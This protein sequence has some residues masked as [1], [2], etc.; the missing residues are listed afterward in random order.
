[1]TDFA[2]M[3]RALQRLKAA[4]EPELPEGFMDGVWMRASELEQVSATRTRLA[5]YL[6]MAFIGLGAGFGTTQSTARAEQV[7]YQL[8]EGVDLSPAALLHI[9]P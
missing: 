3:D 8:A 7:S 4:T 2:Q 9:Q 5:M 1:M 6:A